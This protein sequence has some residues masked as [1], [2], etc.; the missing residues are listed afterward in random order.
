MILYNLR[1][2]LGNALSQGERLTAVDVDLMPLEGALS[3]RHFT[4]HELQLGLPDAP[5][6]RRAV[7][8]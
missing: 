7:F 2:H 8:R 5:V 4:P 1:V 6:A 3:S